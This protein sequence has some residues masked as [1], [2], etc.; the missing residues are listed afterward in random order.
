M[1]SRTSA[2]STFC[3]SL[4]TRS[5]QQ[6]TP[7]GKYEYYQRD[8]GQKQAI[9][10]LGGEYDPDDVQLQQGYG[11]PRSEH[12]QPYPP[13]DRPVGFLLKQ[14]PRGDRRGQRCRGGGAEPGGKEAHPQHELPEFLPVFLPGQQPDRQRKPTRLPPSPTIRMAA[15]MRQPIPKERASPRRISVR[16][17]SAPSPAARKKL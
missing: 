9:D 14:L 10:H 2:P 8:E 12:H 6:R 5:P 17:D 11:E 1:N 15:V 4:L 7:V 13:E 16:L 3:H